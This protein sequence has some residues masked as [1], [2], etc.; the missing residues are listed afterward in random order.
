MLD[1]KHTVQAEDWGYHH[2][3]YGSEATMLH[4][5][6]LQIKAMAERRSIKTEKEVVDPKYGIGSKRHKDKGTINNPLSF[7]GHPVQSEILGQ[8]SRLEALNIYHIFRLTL[9]NELIRYGRHQ[10]LEWHKL[11]NEMKLEATFEF[12]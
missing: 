11:P 2:Q 6:S 3:A 1:P 10:P 9:K 4:L 5:F 12:L 7:W 8:Q